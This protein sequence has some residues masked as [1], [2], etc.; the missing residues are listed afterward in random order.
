VVA[1]DP[2]KT[3]NPGCINA[4]AAELARFRAEAEA[5]ARLQHPNIVQIHEVGEQE[6]VYYLSL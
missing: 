6:G 1:N 5:V 3:V 4:T 2:R